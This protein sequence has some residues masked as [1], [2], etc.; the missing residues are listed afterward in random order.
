MKTFTGSLVA[1]GL[2]VCLGFWHETNAD[3]T[4]ARCDIYPMG[5]DHTSATIPCTFSQRQGYI[6]IDRSDGVLHDLSPTGDQPGNYVDQAGRPVY[7]Q[8]SLGEEGLIF[9]LPDESVFVYW[10]ASSVSAMNARGDVKTSATAP[11][12]TAEYDA[13]TLLACSIGESTHDNTCPAGILR[14]GPGSA[15]VRI[16]N[17]AGEERVLNFEIGDVTTPGGGDLIWRQQ[18]GDW[19]IGIGDR[20]FYLVPEAVVYGG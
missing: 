10:D 12:T 13:T 7:K 8:S 4:D 11:Y 6:M 9:R 20:E 1:S 2:L 18:E 15:T 3:T 14:G 17:P 19:Y 5:E 16:M